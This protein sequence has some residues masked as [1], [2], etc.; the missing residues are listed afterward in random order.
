MDLQTRGGRERSRYMGLYA[1]RAV[2]PRLTLAVRASPN[3]LLPMRRAGN[4]LLARIVVDRRAGCGLSGNSLGNEN[5]FKKFSS[6]LVAL[7]AAASLFATAAF[8]Q[9]SVTVT[10]TSAPAVQ[11]QNDVSVRLSLATDGIDM[12]SVD[13][14]QF[15]FMYDTDVLSFSHIVTTTPLPVGST[16]TF[17]PGVAPHTE[18][19]TLYYDLFVSTPVDSFFDV[20]FDIQPT[21]PLGTT[22]ITFDGPLGPSGILD[23]FGASV[24]FSDVSQDNPQMQIT[25][26]QVAAVPEPAEISM[27]LAG[28]GLIGVAVRRRRRQQA[29]GC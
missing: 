13:F 18:V 12:S 29:V 28:L 16:L 2:P 7:G 6:L 17:Q 23:S 24:D 5:M 26:N 20:F 22:T 11:G 3:R 8:A 14:F 25:V 10:A 9:P 4:R 21:A 19:A 27:L 1:G 15:N